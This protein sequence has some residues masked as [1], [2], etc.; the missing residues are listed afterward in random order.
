MNRLKTLVK[1]EIRATYLMLIYFIGIGIINCISINHTLQREMEEGMISGI[2]G[3]IWGTYHLGNWDY[4]FIPEMNVYVILMLIGVGG[5]IYLSYKNEKS[6]EVGRFLQSL[7]YTTQERYLVKIIIGSIIFTIPYIIYGIGLFVLRN[8][9]IAQVAESYEVTILSE[10]YQEFLGNG[11]LL[12]RL[13]MIYME[14]ITCYVFSVMFQYMISLNL[15]SII[16]AALVG[17][18]PLFMLWNLRFYGFGQSRLIEEIG[19][20]YS[21]LMFQSGGRGELVIEGINRGEYSAFG[22]IDY[23]GIRIGIFAVIALVCIGITLTLCKRYHIENTDILIPS[24]AFRVIFIIGVTVCSG[25]LGGDI[26]YSYENN[27]SN[28]IYIFNLIGILIGLPIAWK[29]AHIG[30]KKRPNIKAVM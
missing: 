9:F 5:L 18:S 10:V 4:M 28:I 13:V 7:P 24:K 27:Y 21:K 8:K 3:G 12:R 22:F 20:F 17:I 26:Y 23:F 15:A 16:I 19:S 6:H 29:I 11:E 1:V 14:A 2:A 30:I 25:M